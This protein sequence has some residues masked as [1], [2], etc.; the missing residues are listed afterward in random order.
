MCPNHIL[1]G[2]KWEKEEPPGTPR[3]KVMKSLCFACKSPTQTEQTNRHWSQGEDSNEFPV[4]PK[5]VIG[6]K[7]LSSIILIS[8]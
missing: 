2:D 1:L 7:T 5:F 8:T 6:F 4:S 3:E